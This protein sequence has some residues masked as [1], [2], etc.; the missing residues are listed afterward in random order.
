[1]IVVRQLGQLFQPD[2]SMVQGVN[3]ALIFAKIEIRIKH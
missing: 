2:R 1:M 3:V